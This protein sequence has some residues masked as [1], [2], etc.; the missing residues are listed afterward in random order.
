MV[1]QANCAHDIARIISHRKDVL[2]KSSPNEGIHSY[3]Y[4]L[5]LIS[6]T[7][8][9]YNVVIQAKDICCYSFWN[10]VHAFDAV[11]R[12]YVNFSYI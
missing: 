6:E 9:V 4:T 11:S 5:M 3:L 1:F 7:H 10:S 12:Y 8:L 2:F